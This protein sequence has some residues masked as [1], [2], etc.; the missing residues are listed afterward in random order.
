METNL[1]QGI[2][3]LFNQKKAQDPEWDGFKNVMYDD[4]T[5]PVNKKTLHGNKAIAAVEEMEGRTL[6]PAER[7]VVTLEGYVP[8][9]YL[10]SKG[11]PTIGVG[12]TGPWMERTFKESYDAHVAGIKRPTTRNR[13]G[14][15]QFD[16]LPEYLQAELIQA[17]YRGDVRQSP[18]A[19]RLLNE[20]LSLPTARKRRER[21]NQA[22]DEFLDNDDYRE[23][24]AKK[25]GIAP[26][27]EAVARAIAKYAE[28][29]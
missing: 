17:E 20:A 1:E 15:P 8:E 12:Q 22:A 23:A 13:G 29:Q 18:T 25:T 24:K 7:R 9:K 6:S 16:S 21:L 10:D 27:M 26:R 19:M 2:I 5:T 28:Q 4:L 14:V 11:V 3:D